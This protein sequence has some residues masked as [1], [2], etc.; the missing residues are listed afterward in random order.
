M[1]KVRPFQPIGAG[2]IKSTNSTS[3]AAIAVPDEADTVAIYNADTAAIVFFRAQ[4]GTA[5]ITAV[6]DKEMPIPPGQLIR[7]SVG[8]GPKRCSIVSTAATG[9]TYITPGIGN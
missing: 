6:V 2:T 4:A 8:Q 7:I 3:A 1:E 5:A 9:V